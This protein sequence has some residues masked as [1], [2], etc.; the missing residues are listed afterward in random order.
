MTTLPR[1]SIS[2]NTAK[3]ARTT[4]LPRLSISMNMAP[5]VLMTTAPVAVVLPL[6]W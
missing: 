2:M 6:F 3:A 5:V 1:L 4:T